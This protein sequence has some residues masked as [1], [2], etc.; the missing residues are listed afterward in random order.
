MVG[1]NAFSTQPDGLWV[2][3][4]PEGPFADVVAIEVCGGVV[5]PN[6]KRSRYMPS[7]TAQQLH[8]TKRWLLSEVPWRSGS[9]LA[10]WQATGTWGDSQ[11]P[12][13]DWVF[14]I[15]FLRVIYFVPD[16]EYSSVAANLIPHGHEFYSRH[17]SL[18]TPNAPQFRRF[19]R[20]ATLGA[21][22]YPLP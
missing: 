19:L 16:A 13:E 17:S 7:T 20:R 1:A 4:W 18:N 22:Y 6:D 3:L 21:H 15:R 8:C 2:F 9:R 14:P 5:N 11:P 10:R 12:S